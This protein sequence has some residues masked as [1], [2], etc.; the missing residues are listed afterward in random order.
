M[1]R[2]NPSGGQIMGILA[3]LGAGVGIALLVRK[4][5]RDAEEAERMS[6]PVGSAQRDT[7]PRVEVRSASGGGRGIQNVPIASQ[8]PCEAKGG[9]IV[10]RSGKHGVEACVPQAARDYYVEMVQEVWERGEEVSDAWERAHWN[11]V[12]TAEL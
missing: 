4:K 8:T 2:N 10:M 5:K 6:H 9:V 7:T 11:A 3:L 12:M 1:N